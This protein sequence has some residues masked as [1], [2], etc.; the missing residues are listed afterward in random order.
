MLKNVN[1][2][3]KGPYIFVEKKEPVPLLPE[4]GSDS[5]SET[6]G[7]DDDLSGIQDSFRIEHPLDSLHQGQ[8][9]RRE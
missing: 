1:W 5:G 3:W 7:S 2:D 9:F 8:H 4:N 6:G